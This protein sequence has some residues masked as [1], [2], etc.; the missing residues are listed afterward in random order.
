MNKLASIDRSSD[1]FANCSCAVVNVKARDKKAALTLAEREVRATV[2]CINF[3][4]DLIPYNYGSLSLGERGLRGSALRLSIAKGGSIH[5]A[6][7]FIGPSVELHFE[8][9]ELFK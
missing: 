6:S 2:E 1:S 8:A 9:L 4:S 3:F 5:F 7:S